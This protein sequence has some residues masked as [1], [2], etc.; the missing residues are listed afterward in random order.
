MIGGARRVRGSL[1]ENGIRQEETLRRFRFGFPVLILGGIFMLGRVG[2]LAAD[3]DPTPCDPT[4]RSHVIVVTANGVGCK[5]AHVS[6]KQMNVIK[7]CS[8][9]GTNLQVFFD[10][11]TPYPKLSQKKPGEWQ[12]GPLEKAEV[13][14]TYKYHVFLDGKEIDPN[15]IIDH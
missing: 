3:C 6:V 9:D 14:R 10:S 7:W 8:A 5:D 15:V 12:S 11:P 2:A 1:G 4:P 13:G